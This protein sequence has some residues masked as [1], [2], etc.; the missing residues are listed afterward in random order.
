MKSKYPYNLYTLTITIFW[1]FSRWQINDIFFYFAPET[2]SNGDNLH[3]MSNP[4][5]WENKKNIQKYRLLQFLPRVL[6]R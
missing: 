5:F 3:E 6:K 2:V 1:A 4:A